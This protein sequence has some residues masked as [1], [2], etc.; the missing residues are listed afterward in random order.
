M[1]VWH[2]INQSTRPTRTGAPL[3]STVLGLIAWAV[4]K[5]VNEDFV[6]LCGGEPIAVRTSDGSDVAP[7]ERVLT[8]VDA[9]PA[10]P[11]A[12]TDYC[13]VTTCA[14]LFGPSGVSVDASHAVLEHQGNPNCCLTVDDGRGREHEWERCDPVEL[15]TYAKLHPSGQAVHVSNFLLN[16]WV[17]PTSRGPFTYMASKGVPGYTEP[18]GPFKSAVGGFQLSYP[19]GSSKVTKVFGKDKLSDLIIRNHMSVIKGFPRKRNGAMHW[20]SRPSR[21]IAARN[22]RIQNLIAS[23]AP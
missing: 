6:P 22:S 17:D 2:L 21:I 14:D 16:A 23:A 7:D 20:S 10:S 18:A 9:L 11:N 1:N 5:Q 19:S 12:H 3:T 13:D 8:F 4:E 15:Q